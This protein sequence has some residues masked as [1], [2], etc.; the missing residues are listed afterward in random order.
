M[1][2]RLPWK[3]SLLLRTSVFAV[4][5][6]HSCL[7]LACHPSQSERSTEKLWFLKLR[8]VLFLKGKLL[9]PRGRSNN[10]LK[11]IL[12]ISQWLFALTRIEAFVWTSPFYIALRTIKTTTRDFMSQSIDWKNPVR[13][14]DL[15]T[16]NRNEIQENLP[17][18]GFNIKKV[19]SKGS[20]LRKKKTHHSSLAFNVKSDCW[21]WQI[22]VSGSAP[23]L[24]DLSRTIRGK[25]PDCFNIK[26]QEKTRRKRSICQESSVMIL[27]WDTKSKSMKSCQV[28]PL[29]SFISRMLHKVKKQLAF[30]GHGTAGSM[31]AQCVSYARADVETPNLEHIYYYLLVSRN[32]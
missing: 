17:N 6:P 2:F 23:L 5:G 11:R 24:S 32:V 25:N 14:D 9:Y 4:Y 22:V 31:W 21:E 16:R 18:D 8:K 7:V 26:S 10:L 29:S 13:W 27:I 12:D 1:S 3:S 20:T 30:Y 15:P 19:C 28:R